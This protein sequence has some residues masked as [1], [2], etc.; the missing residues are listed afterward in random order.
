M[1]NWISI[2]S[3]S[4]SVEITP[5]FSDALSRFDSYG[6]FPHLPNMFS[7]ALL[8]SP[9]PKIKR[10][11]LQMQ[12]YKNKFQMMDIVGIPVK[13]FLMCFFFFLSLSFCFA[14]TYKKEE[15]HLLLKVYQIRGPTEQYFSKFKN[16]NW[17]MDGY[18]STIKV[19]IIW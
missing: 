15:N 4:F 17:A 13:F 11:I 1:N 9:R 2:A 12:F 6:C 3:Y 10:K 8:T 19:V 7:F 16:D 5:N 18:V 14:G